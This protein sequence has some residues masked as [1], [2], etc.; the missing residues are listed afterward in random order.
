M[1]TA[2][3]NARRLGAWVSLRLAVFVLLLAVPVT[4]RAAVFYPETF[5]LANGMQVVV[6]TNRIAPVISHM[7]WYRAGAADE[8]HGRSGVAHYLE[9]LM[10]LG[11]PE[12]P[13]GQFSAIVAR[14]GG[15]ENAFTGA[16]YTAY[17]QEVAVDR[18][19]LVMRLEADRMVNLAVTPERALNERDVI[20]EERRERIDNNPSARL[21]EQMSAALFLNH[22]Y[23]TPIIGWENEMAALTLDDAMAFYRTW[24]APNNAILVV[25]GDIDAAT[26]RPLAEQTYGQ[27]PARPVP[28]RTRP[29]E[30]EPAAA[31]RVELRDAGVQ[32][33]AWRRY[34][35]APSYVSGPEG[36]AYALEVLNEILGGITGRF[37]RSLVVEQQL[38]VD[39]GTSYS[40]DDLDQSIFLGYATPRQGVELSALEAAFD[41]EIARLLRDGVTAEELDSARRRLVIEATYARDSVSGPARVLGAALAV[42]HTVE[43][44]EAWPDRINAVTAEDVLAAARHVLAPERSV[45]GVLL[46]DPEH[47]GSRPVRPTAPPHASGPIR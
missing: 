6:V 40:P 45:T 39:A 10:F 22:P 14:N 36:Q 1:P 24:Y 43:Q 20:I 11:T 46:P 47:A 34:Y 41:A 3:A 2:K 5:T 42:G 13:E 38:A 30:P 7:V 25:S 31:R 29:R 37:Y 12:V 35:L 23:G 19:P 16:D 8:P 17:Y 26:L 28:A 21:A 4:A 18:L 9:H 44:V 32:L 33:P 15:Q 27:I